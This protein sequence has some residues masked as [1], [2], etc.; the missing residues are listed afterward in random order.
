MKKSSKRALTLQTAT[1][2]RLTAAVGGALFEY[3]PTYT[4][5]G[6]SGSPPKETDTCSW[7]CSK[8]CS[9]YATCA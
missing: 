1:I 2:R 6:V 7:G 5:I 4:L 9:N 8:T 3:E